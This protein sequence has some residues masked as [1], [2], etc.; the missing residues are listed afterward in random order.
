LRRFLVLGIAALVLGVG[1]LPARAT[2][3]YNLATLIN[4]DLS[5]TYGDK[6]F[7][8]FT[9]QVT[10]DAAIPA[11]TAIDVTTITLNGNLGI[12]FQIGAL[13]APGTH[14]DALLGYTVTTT[15][16]N[17]IT[18]VHLDGNP[19]YQGTG[20]AYVNAVE[21]V[22]AVIPPATPPLLGQISVYANPSGSQLS[23]VLNLGSGYTQL[24]ILKDIQL[25]SAADS[26]ATSSLSFVNQTFSQLPEPT[27]LSG[28]G[29]A[30]FFGLACAW[31]RRRAKAA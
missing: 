28:A 17:L 9:Y 24:N 15:G 22:Y 21:S 31:R 14:G 6:V 12:Q 13:A 19:V 20:Y 5:I 3:T 23:D 25:F 26:T 1:T 27:T 4:G 7:S 18:D 11:A 2:Q 30:V 29:I 8:G 16:G 10:G